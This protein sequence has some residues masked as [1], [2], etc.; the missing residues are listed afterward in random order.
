MTKDALDISGLG[1]I[2]A[3]LGDQRPVVCVV[4]P[5]GAGKTF[6][7]LGLAK[8]LQ[9]DTHQASEI[10]REYVEKLPNSAM[11]KYIEKCLEE[12]SQVDSEEACSLIVQRAFSSPNRLSILDGFPRTRKASKVLQNFC[13]LEERQLLVFHLYAPKEVCWRRYAQKHG[14]MAQAQAAFEKRCEHYSKHERIAVEEL[15]EGMV[16][17]L[18]NQ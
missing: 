17:D 4:G 3:S 12:N 2:F 1:Q 11:T 10:L 9:G 18:Y 5:P 7:S 14:N 13:R 6:F 16:I 8:L 15:E